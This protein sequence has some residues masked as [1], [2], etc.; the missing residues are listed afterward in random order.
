MSKNDLYGEEGYV[1][2]PKNEI[3]TKVGR[4]LE[5]KSESSSGPIGHNPNLWAA[6]I[7]TGKKKQVVLT[8]GETA[9][10][11]SRK[12]ATRLKNFLK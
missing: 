10:I 8:L 12:Q 1:I 7:T 2:V 9:I 3:P 4:K 6:H 11:L 5:I